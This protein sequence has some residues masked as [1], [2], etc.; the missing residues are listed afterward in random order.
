M[1]PGTAVGFRSWPGPWPRVGGTVTAGDGPRAGTSVAR[2]SRALLILRGIECQMVVVVRRDAAVLADALRLPAEVRRVG[3]A[4]AQGGLFSTVL[5]GP[6]RSASW[7]EWSWLDG[8]E[9]GRRG[10]IAFFIAPWVEA[11]FSALA[12]RYYTQGG[13]CRVLLAAATLRCDGELRLA[14]LETHSSLL[15][16]STPSP[17]R[18]AG[19]RHLRASLA[20]Y[21]CRPGR[22]LN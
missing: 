22:P 12:C 18:S 10:G 9:S 21:K 14:R 4:R 1:G 6:P 17:G 16:E 3:P 2:P 13:E 20:S 5:L 8:G 19:L 15:S 11:A 7:A